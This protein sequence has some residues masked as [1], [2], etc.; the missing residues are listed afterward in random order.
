[1]NAHATHIAAENGQT[2]D[3]VA[4]RAALRQATRIAE[5]ASGLALALTATV[6]ATAFGLLYGL[7]NRAAPSYVAGWL[8]ILCSLGIVY[9]VLFFWIQKR[10]R[11]AGVPVVEARRPGPL[12]IALL[13]VGLGLYVV[14]GAVV[15]FLVRASSAYHLMLIIPFGIMYGILWCVHGVQV[16][17]W[18]D[19]VQGITLGAASAAAFLK[20]DWL[21]EGWL[22]LFAA[23]FILSGIVKHLRWRQWVRTAEAD[24][25]AGAR[26]G[27]AS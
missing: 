1:M 2:P 24:P 14:V 5:S 10:R 20:A 8:A 15:A 22:I 23:C 27:G 13:S 26:E 16:G 6:V 7:G 4:A 19:T 12:K 17:Q 18:E 21:P 25:S 11:R 9:W 3:T